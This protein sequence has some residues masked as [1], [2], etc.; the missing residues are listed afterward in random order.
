LPRAVSRSLP[1]PSRCCGLTFD[2]QTRLYLPVVFSVLAVADRRHSL[3][4]I[5]H[6]L[7]IAI[8]PNPIR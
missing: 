2:W 7:N 5:P 4:N 1:S 6:T 8:S 3:R